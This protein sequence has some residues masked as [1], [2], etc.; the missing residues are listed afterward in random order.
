M[1]WKSKLAKSYEDFKKLEVFY[2][3]NYPNLYNF[4]LSADYLY[5]KLLGKGI[6]LMAIDDNLDVIGTISLTYKEAL[7]NK[8]QNL[9]AEI[10]DSYVPL[11]NQRNFKNNIYLNGENKFVNNSI[12]GRLVHEI[13]EYSKKIGINFIYGTANNQSYRG[14]VKNLN[15]SD[16]EDLKIYSYI[17]PDKKIFKKKF[18]NFL[19]DIL[20][21]LFKIYL[22]SINKFFFNNIF[23][24]EDKNPQKQIIENLWFEHKDRYDFTLKKNFNYFEKKYF[25][26]KNRKFNYFFAYHKKKIIAFFVFD[27]NLD[28]DKAFLIDNLF[29]KSIT[30][31]IELIMISKFYLKV[32]KSIIFWNKE[33]G[34]VKSIFNIYKSKKINIIIRKNKNIDLK[35]LRKD[36]SLGYSDNF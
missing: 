28:K 5:E 26:K 14:Y 1:K 35:S 7:I 33:V 21:K 9:I 18:N 32:K 15:F 30:Q 10:G 25:Q 31:K 27:L 22:K 13:V 12:F 29:S 36:F 16:F 24:Q 17:L 2:K 4:R 11:F 3:K 19:A 23:I 20:Y 34:I 8:N 6:F